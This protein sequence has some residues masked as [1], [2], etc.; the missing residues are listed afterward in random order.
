MEALSKILGVSKTT[1]TSQNLLGNQNNHGVYFTGQKYN[2]DKPKFVCPICEDREI[3]VI[4]GETAVP[5]E[6]KTKKAVSKRLKASGLTPE[7]MKY[8]IEQYKVTDQNKSLY[9]GTKQYLKAWPELINSNSRSKGFCMLG[10]P[11]IGKTMLTCIIAKD[12]LKKG[13][14]VVF[15]PS[16]D[17]MAELRQ[18]Q[19]RDDK[20]SMESKIE[21]LGTTP[22]LILD[23][24]GKEKPT[25]W[26]QSMYYRLVDLRYRNNLLTG[27]TSNYFMGELEERLGEFGP[28]TVSRLLGMARDYILVAEGE[29]WRMK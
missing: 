27:F 21:T 11:G 17:L 23:D 2:Q 7:Q 15:V 4:D 13:V 14:P 12:M 8:T 5:C 24:V 29:D 1:P 10:T 25:E 18:A 16:T 9:Q 19:F 3:V 22:A 6:C 28:A 26:V 20:E